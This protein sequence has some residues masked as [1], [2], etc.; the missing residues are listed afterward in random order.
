MV[1][2]KPA[3]CAKRQ[4]EILDRAAE[5]LRPGGRIVYSTCTMNRTEN[6]DT[7]DAFLSR[8]A[9]FSAEAFSLPGAD[10]PDG[11]LTCYPHRMKGEGHFVALLRKH[12][13]APCNWQK[14]PEKDA[15]SKDALQA[16]RA[17]CPTANANVMRTGSGKPGRSRDE[18]VTL[19]CLPD[20]PAC[21][22]IQVVRCGLQLGTVQKK[23]FVPD[24]AWAMSIFPPDVPR[25]ELTREDARRYQAGET[26]PADGKGWALACCDGIPLGWGKISDGQMK[27]HYPKGLRRPLR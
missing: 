10:A 12:G 14:A 2:R 21:D 9:D 19:S 7:V 17:F 26:L 11:M 1:A 16:L 24:H 27:N 25:V 20:R 13:D 3:G 18:S 8:H 23:L 15:P 5:M 22:G 6:E 4:A